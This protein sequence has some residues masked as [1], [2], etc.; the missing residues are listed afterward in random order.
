[1]GQRIHVIG[2]SCSGKSTLAGQLART[3]EVPF[4]ELDA[5]NWLPNWT[6]LNATNPTELERRIAMKSTRLRA[7]S[8]SAEPNGRLRMSRDRD[9]LSGAVRADAGHVRELVERVV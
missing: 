4:V 5:L 6:G 8:R 9:A 3:L 2:N 7:R 1:V